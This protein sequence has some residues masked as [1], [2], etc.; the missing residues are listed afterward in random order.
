MEKFRIL[1]L[2]ICRHVMFLFQLTTVRWPRSNHNA[3]LKYIEY[4]YLV[5]PSNGTTSTHWQP[6]L[7]EPTASSGA[8]PKNFQSQ[9]T[10]FYDD[11]D[12]K[13]QN[14]TT[15]TQTLYDSNSEIQQYLQDAIPHRRRNPNPLRKTSK[16][17]RQLPKKSNRSSRH[18]AQFRPLHLPSPKSKSLLCSLVTCESSRFGRERSVIIVRNLSWYVKKPPL[19]HPFFSAGNVWE[20]F[21]FV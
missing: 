16:L 12:F 18:N 21:L 9:P 20:N 2:S 10:E 3:V 13:I 14:S 17:H 4:F 8:P 1:K 19:P 6:Y 5:P 7:S 11:N 15:S